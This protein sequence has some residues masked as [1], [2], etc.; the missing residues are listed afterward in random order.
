MCASGL[1]SVMYAAQGIQLGHANTVVAGGFESM[2]NVPYYLDGRCAPFKLSLSLKNHITHFMNEF[3][4]LPVGSFT[5]NSS[6]VRE[7]VFVWAMVNSSMPL[8]A[9]AFGTFTTTST[10]T[11]H[12][13]LGDCLSAYNDS[14]K[15]KLR[16][17][18]R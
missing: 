10:C 13:H 12:F 2:S 17:E 15:G 11:F 16:G 5:H 18:L 9:M 8:S 4:A 1:K 3:N 6:L 14:P 7:T